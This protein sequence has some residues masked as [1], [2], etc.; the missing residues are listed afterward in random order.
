MCKQKQPS[1]EE[2]IEK[3]KWFHGAEFEKYPINDEF[4]ESYSNDKTE[5]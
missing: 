3:L 2:I 4:N 5:L 1:K